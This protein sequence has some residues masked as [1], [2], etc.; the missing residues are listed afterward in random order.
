MKV[1][2]DYM[3]DLHI[4][5]HARQIN[6][7]IKWRKNTLDVLQ[8]CVD[9]SKIQSHILVLAGDISHWNLQT[10]W[11]LEYFAELYD[12]VLMTYGNHDLYLVSKTQENKYKR[13]SFKRLFEIIDFAENHDK[14]CLL[15]RNRP[16]KITTEW[17][18]KISVFGDFMYYPL[19]STTAQ[20][21]YENVS[22]DSSFVLLESF[23]KEYEK[24]KIAY[25]NWLQNESQQ[26]EYS[27]FVP[28]VPPIWTP[29]HS[30][31]QPEC[32][33][34]PVDELPPNTIF[35]HTHENFVKDIGGIQ[36]A[37]NTWG[38]D[39]I[40]TIKTLELIPNE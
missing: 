14:I 4:D 9:Q 33:L 37:T 20:N 15:S 18:S 31:Y 19:N 3:S 26:A 34:A 7:T 10:K 5:F 2:V 36:W 6:N 1:T 25:E 11:V 22:N 12:K 35:G 28:H 29:S 16:T 38:Y 21:F 32:Y 17:G 30:R 13:D 23:D 39:K 27:L 24:S 40:G 8:Q